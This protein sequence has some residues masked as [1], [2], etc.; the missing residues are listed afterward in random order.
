ML[1]LLE[2]LS[3][4]YRACVNRSNMQEHKSLSHIKYLRFSKHG[5]IGKVLSAIV[6]VQVALV[7]TKPYEPYNSGPYHS[8]ESMAKYFQ[9]RENL[10]MSG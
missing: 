4:F 7:L 10:G 1:Q 2:A 3:P 5:F 9:K 8:H 6:A